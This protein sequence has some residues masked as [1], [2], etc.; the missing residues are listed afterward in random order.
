MSAEGRPPGRT[1]SAQ[2][3]PADH[4]EGALMSTNTIVPAATDSFSASPRAPRTGDDRPGRRPS[5]L[6]RFGALVR[7]EATILLRN[8]TA[9]FTA[10]LMPPMMAV[11]FLQLGQ[12]SGALG[13]VLVMVLLGTGLLFVVYYTMV[14]SLVA[15]RE[16]LVLKRLRTGEAT[17]LEILLAPAVPLWALLTIETGMGVALASAALGAVP[18]HPWALVPAV[19]LGSATWTALAVWSANF[20]RTVESAQLTTMPAILIT[21]L[22]SGFSLPLDAF[23]DVV[24]RLAHALPLTPVVDLV[25]LAFTGAGTAGTTLSGVDAAL[26]ALGMVIPL[27]AWTAA[28]LWEGVRGFRWEPRS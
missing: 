11:M 19:V 17:T 20:T 24:Q 2:P 8:K 12:R 21:L 6:R 23:P 18:V 1:A 15:R 16:Q 27:V 13:S 22:F 10:V 5:A 9:M 28:A 3:T 7:A 14:T 25:K 26:G 4:P